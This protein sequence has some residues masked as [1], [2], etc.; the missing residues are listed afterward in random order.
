[1]VERTAENGASTRAGGAEEPNILFTPEDA[2]RATEAVLTA[3]D[4]GR[5]QALETLELVHRARANLLDRA[6]E[7]L[8]VRTDPRAQVLAS[9]AEATNIVAQRLRV[10]AARA[11][12]KEPPPAEAT[13][14]VHGHVI[15]ERLD[16]V[17][18]VNVQVVD[19]RGRRV[20]G[21]SAATD[22]QGY[23]VLEWTPPGGRG[24]KT[25]AE[26]RLRVMKGSSR[27]LHEERAPRRRA[28]GD[29]EYAEIV[30]PAEQG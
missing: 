6:V 7:G 27:V 19:M 13:A 11:R 2:A 25:V 10:E 22:P 3:A 18:G 4:E 8:D 14:K 9:A 16:P 26:V 23:F 17:E 24:T 15:D 5:A 29:V 20:R 30:V 21:A 28:A 12:I 1:V